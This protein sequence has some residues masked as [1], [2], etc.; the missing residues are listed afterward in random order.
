MDQFRHRGVDG[1][2]GTGLRVAIR[3]HRNH[4][5]IFCWGAGI[6]HRGPLN[7]LHFAAKEEDPTRWT[8]SNHSPWTG[9]QKADFT[10]FVS[11]MDYRDLP[12]PEEP[13]LRPNTGY[14]P[15]GRA[16][17]SWCRDTRRIPNASEWRPGPP[18]PTTPST[19]G[20]R[21]RPTEREVG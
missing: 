17:W 9:T 11:N 5:S 15:T 19:T 2:I 12:A 10:D 7:P 3:N 16:P 6:N 18:T 4:P 8:A 13:F 20:N 14:R 1:A 21:S